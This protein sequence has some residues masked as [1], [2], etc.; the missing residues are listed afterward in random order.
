M[1]GSRHSKNA[2]GMN[3]EGMSYNERRALGFGTQKER[4]GKA[5]NLYCVSCASRRSDSGHQNALT[6]TCVMALVEYRVFM[7]TIPYDM[8]MWTAP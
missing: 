7:L 3:C 6:R 5:P 1:G 2:G 8:S 4:L